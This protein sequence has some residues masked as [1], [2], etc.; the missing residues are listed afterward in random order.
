MKG[1]FTEYFEKF[2]F[3][4]TAI[5]SLLGAFSRVGE[6]ALSLVKNAYTSGELDCVKLN[7]II[8]SIVKD[9]GEDKKVVNFLAVLSLFPILEQRLIERGVPNDIIFNT[10]IDLK[11]KCRE[12]RKVFGEHGLM[13]ATWFKAIL[14][15]R[16]FGIGRLQFEIDAFR[17]EEYRSGDCVVKKGEP[18]LSIHIPGSNQPFTEDECKSAYKGAVKFFHEFFPSVF[19]E[20]VPLVSWTWLLYPKNSEFMLER[21]NILRFQKDF[22]I[23]ETNV[24][25]TNDSIAWRIFGVPEIKDI[26]SLPEDT[27]L[28]KRAKAYIQSGKP[29]G[30]GYGVFFEKE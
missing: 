24:Y 4:K 5:T 13:D 29:F 28:Q 22:D 14:E 30:W 21:S 2:G 19:G 23:I 8:D 15:E 3:E 1:Y 17:L 6:G 9:C 10:L 12:C 7:E 27:S 20:Y 18:V 25:K 16:C 26:S 11:Y